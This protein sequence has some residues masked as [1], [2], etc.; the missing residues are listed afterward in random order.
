[1]PARGGRQCRDRSA[2]HH[3]RGVRLERGL[4]ADERGD[5]RLLLY[6]APRE[7]RTMNTPMKEQTMA[8][9]LV[10]STQVAR[11]LRV[12]VPLIRD[13]LKQAEEAGLPHKQAA[14]LKLLE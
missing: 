14:G 1:M 3:A 10:A 11:P 2:R 12:L 5:D 4:A 8:I 7:P 13:D 6:Q 9:E